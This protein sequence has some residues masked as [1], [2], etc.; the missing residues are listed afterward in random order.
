VI[1]WESGHFNVLVI[2][3]AQSTQRVRHLVNVGAKRP[4][5]TLLPSAAVDIDM[6]A[7][8]DHLTM[9]APRASRNP[10]LPQ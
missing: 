1:L 9:A 4:S 7:T 6:S 8:F 2:E 10:E 5:I 3:R